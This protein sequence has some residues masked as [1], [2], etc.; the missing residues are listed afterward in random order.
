MKATDFIV[1]LLKENGI[2]TI[3]GH[4]GGFNADFVDSVFSADGVNFVLNYHEQAA[5]FS[6]NAHSMVTENVGIATSSGAPSTCNLIAGVANSF[7]DSLPCVFIAGSVH[8]KALRASPEIRQNAFEEIDVVSMVSG[9]TKYAVKIMSP[10]DLR[11]IF[12]KAIYIAKSGRPGPVLIDLPYDI[13][14]S[15]VEVEK[16]KGFAP[17]NVEEY[18]EIDVKKIISL[19]SKAKKP[20]ILLGGGA[21]SNHC[22]KKIRELLEKVKVPVVASLCGLDAVQHNNGCFAGFIGH[23]GNRYAN[24]SL[25]YSDFVL[26]LGS[27]LDERQMG[28]FRSRLNPDATVV[29]VDVDKIELGRRIPETISI[30]STAEKFLDL[31]VNENFN[32]CDFSKWFDVISVWK[33]RYPSFDLK[34]KDVNANNFLHVISDYLPKNALICADVGQNQMCAAQTLRLDDDRRLFNTGG[35]GSMGY[36]LPA[37]IG[38]SFAAKGTMVVSI[39]GDGGI[40]MNIQEL[41]AIVRDNLPINIIVL[42]NNCLGMIRRLQEN[43]FDNRLSA[44]VDGYTVPN[45]SA[46]SAAYGIPYLGIHKVEEYHLVK[47]FISERGPTMIEVFLPRDMQNYPEPGA[48]LDRQTP[49]LSEEENDLV[50]RESIF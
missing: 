37:A 8:S 49:L 3:F 13:A 14:R 38:L 6:A 1:S 43:M 31:F 23:Y 9:I 41:Q 22:R 32:G 40:Q 25:A 45:Y 47:D 33:E 48:V 28:G 30:H 17:E 35:Y 19:L 36:A 18:D 42:N 12:E 21:R 16:L 27:R 50:K 2:K 29:R 7:F 5:A 4:L 20:V 44:S 15:H 11:Y 26:V 34:L 39:N 10:D 24:F 46:I